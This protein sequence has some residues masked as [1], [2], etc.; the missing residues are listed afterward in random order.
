MKMLFTLGLLLSVAVFQSANAQGAFG[1]TVGTFDVSQAGSAQYSIPI[2]APPGPHGVQPHIA[3]TYDNLRGNG[4]EGMGWSVSGLSGINRCAK[5]YAQDGTPSAVALTISDGYCLDGKRLRLTGG[6]YGTAGSTYQTEIADFSQITA[7][8]TEGNGPSTFTVQGKDG[9]IY[10]YGNGG[11]SQVLLGTTAVAWMLNQVS[12]RAGNTMT[13]S[14]CPAT[15]N[16]PSASNLQG[17]T[18]PATISWTPSSHGSSSYN[19]TMQFTYSGISAPLTAGY[20]AGS[21][22]QNSYVLNNIQI[23]NLGTTLK[24]YVLGFTASASTTRETLT[25]IKECSDAGAT[26]CLLPTII[27]YQ[28]GVPGFMNPVLSTGSGPTNG[29]VFSVDING[30]GKQDLV[31]AVTSGSNYQWWVQFAAAIGYLTPINTGAVSPI[32]TTGIPVV[33]GDFLIDDFDATGGNEILAPVGGTWFAYKWNGT[34]FTATSTGI[35]V[36]A[37]ALYA[38]ADVDGDGRPDLVYFTQATNSIFVQLNTSAGGAISF[39]TPVV[40]TSPSPL[41]FTGFYGNNSQ[42]NSSV[43]H[44]DFDGDGR[45]DLIVAIPG[46]H[47]GGGVSNP[48]V[49]PLLSRGTG[50]FVL[51]NGTSSASTNFAAVNWND[52]ACTDLIV[53]LFVIISQC[54]GNTL[55]IVDLPAQPSLALDWDGDGRTDVLANVSGFWEVYRSEGNAVAAGVSTGISVASGNYIVTDQ[56]GDGLDDV[57][58]VN[59]SVGNALSYGLNNGTVQSPDLVSAFADGYGVTY[60][61]TYFTLAASPALYTKGTGAVFPNQDYSGPIFVVNSYAGSDGVGGTYDMTY[62]YAGAIMNLQGRGFE[63]FTTISRTDSGTGFKDTRTY[64]T[65]FPSTGMLSAESVTQSTGANVSVGTSTLASLALDTTPNNQRVFPYTASSSV[66]TYEVQV[67]GSYNGQLITTATMSRSTPDIYGNSSSVVKSVTDEDSGSPYFGQAWTTTTAR[68]ITASPS[69]WCNNLPT[70]RDI[71]NTAPGVPA[72]TR[73]VS[74]TPDYSFCRETQQVVESGNLTHQVT[75]GLS[76]DSFGNVSGQ[77]VTGVGMAAR[78]SSVNWGTTGQLPTTSTNALSQITHTNFDPNSGNPLSVQDPNGIITSWVYDAFQRK[79]Q[80]TRPDGTT[81]TWAYNNCAA[82]GC[83]NSNNR[84][85][86]VQTNVNVGGLTLNTQNTYLD[87]FDRTLVTSKQMLNNAFD[88]NEIQYDNRGNVHQQAAPCTFVS[89]VAYWTVNT[90]DPLNRL[91]TIQRPI[92]ATN[93]RLQT[94]TMLYSGRTTTVTDPQG[95]VTATIT[96]V[97]GKV[98][99][100]KDNNGYFVNFNQ[101]AFGSLLTV[102]DSLSNT[103]RTMTY[104]YGLKAFRTSLADMDLG[105]RSYSPDALGEIT[106]Y[107]DGKGQHF[108]AAYD[109]LSRMTTRT[110]PDLTTTWTWGATAASFNI[111]KLASVSSVSTTSGTHTDSYTFDSKGRLSNHTVT[112]PTDGA[113]AFDYAYDTTTGLLSTLTYPAFPTFRLE[114]GYTYQNGIMKSIFKVGTPSTIWWQANSTNPRGQITQ[115]ATQDASTD[116]EIVSTRTY[117]AVTGWLGSI[118]SG[119][120]GGSTLQNEAYLHDEM[121][122]VTQRQNNNLGLTE[123]FFYDNLYRLDHSTLGGVT[124]LQMA[125]D[126]MGDIT[127]KSD[128]AAGATWT[129]DPVRKHAVTQAGSPSISYAYDAN[130]NVSSRNGSIIGWTS[131]NYPSGVTTATESAT[132][133]YGPDRQRWRMIYTGPTGTET[134]YYATPMFEAVYTSSGTDFRH[135]IFAPD[136]RAVMQLSRSTSGSLQRS[137]LTDHQG[138]ISSMVSDATGASF[139]SESYT[140][141]GNRREAST[142][143]GTPTSAELASMNA[144]TRQGYTFQT[145]LGTMGLN[146]MNGRIEDSITGRFLSPDPRGTIQDNTQSWNRYSYVI[147]NPLTRIDPTGFEDICG[148]DGAGCLTDGGDGGGGGG[149]A[150]GGVSAL[151]TKLEQVTV[152]ASKC[153]ANPYCSKYSAPDSWPTPVVPSDDLSEINVTASKIKPKPPAENQTPPPPCIASTSANQSTPSNT[154]TG[155]LVGFVVGA[156]AV[157]AANFFGAPEVEAAEGVIFLEGGGTVAVASTPGSGFAYF[158]GRLSALGDAPLV[159]TNVGGIAAAGGALTAGV[160]TP[161]AC[162]GKKP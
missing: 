131:Y 113:R 27:T 15:P 36:V 74:F 90:Y 112:N 85:T 102:T 143:T 123:N 55:Q 105:S 134:T 79:Q 91:L 100:T 159:A 64:S 118:Q 1:R 98:G 44:F 86:V 47:S 151:P 72:I 124:N 158:L 67:G 61:P 46:V 30:D 73:H 114:A 42:S 3:L 45:R 20:I 108:S 135:Y 125:Y 6:T 2:W 93:S 32:P 16:C 70:E 56:N 9:L 19:Y 24:N 57:V 43:K 89:C 58:F 8:G 83:V 107:S 23:E 142:W 148:D 157:L 87:A 137:F 103:L 40:T 84:T 53:G 39:S 129:Y 130:G 37:G 128:V 88:R 21:P 121:G 160:L 150:N 154:K 144:I 132:F 11:N 66:N 101:D 5:T 26:S 139:V 80:E 146:H 59:A 25:S 155:A 140:A 77:T 97:S 117:D 18:L 38:S 156:G 52:D 95:K 41:G 51:G 149:G 68:T 162:I 104:A 81:T 35:A 92:S 94:T 82:A 99:R 109:V 29:T 120:T 31:F 126:A 122:N 69:T 10:Q 33:Q 116:P 145:V 54:N 76:Y 161:S 75:T 4:P 115:E 133:D 147:N 78:T 50:P 12:D 7:N 110:E 141:F 71:T 22:V 111:G 153:D 63:G 13:V 60:M 62:A 106:T 138:S 14:Y 136:G 48:S 152:T 17:M 119:V 65:V 34:S 127:S 96:K 49:A 28:H